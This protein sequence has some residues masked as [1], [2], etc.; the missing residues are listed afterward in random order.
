MVSK[1]P[2]NPLVL[3]GQVL[4]YGV[5]AVIIG[6]FSTSPKYTHLEPNLSLIKL[7]FSYH[8]EP[9]GECHQRTKEE[10][11]QL[12]PNMRAPTSC[13]RERSPVRVKIDLDGQLLFEGAAPPA[14]L[15]KDGTSTIYKR[16]EVPSGEHMLSVK[17]NDN[18]RIK[19]FN[20]VREEKVTLKP[21][22][23]LVIDLRRDHGGIFF[24]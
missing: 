1:S 5:F 20:H 24:E 15:S 2:F 4:F 3:V 7:S 19:D 13:P 12:A 22:Q 21:A 9:V 8:G 10:L 6:Y 11:A 17:M 18:V 14:G 16:F 23:I